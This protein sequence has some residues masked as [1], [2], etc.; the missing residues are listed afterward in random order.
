MRR[1]S[2]V[3]EIQG[4][5]KDFAQLRISDALSS[6]PQLDR[7]E[8]LADFNTKGAAVKDKAYFL[9]HLVDTLMDRKEKV[10]L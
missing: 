2:L 1:K 9:A 10:R 6:L 5:D 4:M 3:E 8:I 7:E